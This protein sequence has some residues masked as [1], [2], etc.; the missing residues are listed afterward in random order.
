MPI[1]Q[2]LSPPWR[3]RSL[4]CNF[5]AYAGV[6]AAGFRTEPVAVMAPSFARVLPSPTLK[7]R[8]HC[9]RRR[10]IRHKASRSRSRQASLDSVVMSG[11]NPSPAELVA[12]GQESHLTMT[13]HVR[14]ITELASLRGFET[15]V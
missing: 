2:W 14:G 15:A 4:R 1:N 6:E 5:G 7:S 3:L 12:E 10:L 9:G 8:K 11:R 13:E